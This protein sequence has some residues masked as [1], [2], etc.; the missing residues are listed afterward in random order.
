MKNLFSILFIFINCFFWAQQ[1]LEVRF[2]NETVNR[3]YMV[4][5]D[6]NELMPISAQFQI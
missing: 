2:Y 6:N 4:Y 5:A 1:K 3:E